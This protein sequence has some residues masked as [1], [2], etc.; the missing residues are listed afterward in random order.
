MPLEFYI[1]IFSILGAIIFGIMLSKFNLK[2]LKETKQ[3]RLEQRR[4]FK[5]IKNERLRIALGIK[6][7]NKQ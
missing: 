7:I 3:I 4:A 5:K 6:K 2:I 1:S